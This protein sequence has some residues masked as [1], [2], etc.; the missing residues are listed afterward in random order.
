MQKNLTF[1]GI[2]RNTDN[3]YS[4]DGECVEMVN[5]RIE[6]G[7]AVP[8]ARPR[9]LASLPREYKA[10][11]R[12]EAADVY[13]CI[14][15]EGG[16]VYL[17]DNDFKPF[18][19]GDFQHIE[20]VPLYFD[21]NR[22]E[23][24]G[25]LVCFF[26]ST[27][28]LYALYDSGKYKRLGERPEMPTLSFNIYSQ[29]QSVT[30][31][32]K[33]RTGKT[34]DDEDE[35]LYW[36]NA[37]K[38]YFDECVSR[39]NAKGCYIDRA[40]FRY[41]FRLFDG[42]YAF[43]S[44]IYYVVDNTLIDDFVYDKSNFIS[45][46]D[47]ANAS[48]TY[49]TVKVK[50][51]VPKFNF[52]AFQFSEWENVIV[53]VDV[54]TSGSIAGHKLG[55]DN[56]KSDGDI[57][58][59]DIYQVKSNSEIYD[60]ITS[61]ALFYK[62]AEYDLSGRLVDSL[63]NVSPSSLALAQEIGE[64]SMTLVSR[65]ADYTYVFNGRLHLAGLR[66]TF[67]KGYDSEYFV[68]VGMS[69]LALSGSVYF[70]L[71][72]TDGVSVVRRNYEKFYVGLAAGQYYIAPLLMYPDAR[73]TKITFVLHSGSRIYRKSFPLT[74]HKMLNVA[75]YLNTSNDGIKVT[76]SGIFKN[77]VAL[78]LLSERNVK[79]FFSYRPGSY[80]LVYN[81]DGV[82]M[83][84]ER[85]FV[86]ASEVDGGG[87]YGT[88]SFFGE[89]LAGDTITIEIEEDC[90]ANEVK[91]IIN[92]LVDAS[93]EQLPDEDTTEEEN[94]VEVRGN[95]LRVSAVD[96]PFTFPL[97]QTY[98]PSHRNI[99]AICS[100]TFALSQ[101]QFGQHPLYV[102]C[103]DGIWAMACDGSASLAY[104]ACYPLSREV[105]V[106]ARSV[107]GID[108]GVV[109][110]T[111]KGLLLIEGGKVVPLSAPLES[112]KYAM[113]SMSKDSL[114]GRIAA[115]VS[116]DAALDDATFKEYC[117]DASVGYVYANREIIVT[118][119]C[120]P[121]SYIISLATGACYKYMYSFDFVSNCYPQMIAMKG[122]EGAS[123][124]FIQDGDSGDN[125][126]LLVTRPLLWGTKLHKRIQQMMLHS[127][128]VPPDDA[129]HSFN[130][131][132]CYLLC[133]NDGENFKMVSGSERRNAFVDI[134]FPY[135]PTQSYRYFAVAIVGRI[136]ARSRLVALEFDV[137]TAWNNRLS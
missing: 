46:P 15:K 66:E 31:E 16:A 85:P 81:D 108:S 82:W 91:G 5:L 20:P 51:F 103:A 19:S 71:N 17:Y 61:C 44:P 110:M 100:N 67:F 116:V 28:T 56:K 69:K 26:T 8:I 55:A 2:V 7:V 79:A 18:G 43:F 135:F 35:N 83:Y 77:Q 98:T 29:V 113:Q 30:T 88:F 93:W 90:F 127:V 87:Y 111:E 10:L 112:G 48:S 107:K 40:L 45:I 118:N 126:I 131:L 104:T 50:G 22:I 34:T 134:V 80:T 123:K 1:K 124:V 27:A 132:A 117:R 54:F 63:A 65:T 94:T 41:A 25:N 72:T 37:S 115:I 12:H 60:D 24:L 64:E 95:I 68:P 73:A 105:C 106:N 53:S 57:A 121:Y 84:N 38:G 75:Y 70:E 119:S 21:V 120:Y 4:K 89:P 76:C 49:Y 96:N 125:N 58:S 14:A 109:F 59:P 128:V 3:L 101:G 137:D 133:S 99:V 97:A 39:L 130:G 36:E 78:Y 47:D 6:N 23:F 62:V 9:E 136:K 11:Y 13:M 102:F 92:I 122:G 32:Y 74:R 86:I 42:S 33:Y 114:I 52:S 129:L